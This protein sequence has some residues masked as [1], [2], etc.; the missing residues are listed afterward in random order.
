MALGNDGLAIVFS[1][2]HNNHRNQIGPVILG[3]TKGPESMAR[4]NVTF[5]GAVV[6]KDALR[7]TKNDKSVINITLVF[8]RRYFDDSANEWKDDES[9][10]FFINASAFNRL[11]ENIDKTLAPGDRVIGSGTIRKKSDWTDKNGVLH[12]NDTEI[13]LDTIGPDLSSFRE[14]T[15]D[16]TRRG[17]DDSPAPA[18]SSAPRQSRPKAAPKK[19]AAVQDPFAGDFDDFD[20]G[21]ADDG[22]LMF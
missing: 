7:K 18:Q 4:M 3:N 19:P 17:G 15:I 14:V 8:E 5:T 6:R 10:K 16:H 13:L 11:A 2:K 1:T 21:T 9:A 12:N 20:D 22:D